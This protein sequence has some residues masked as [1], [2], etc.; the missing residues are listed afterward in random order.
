MQGRECLFQTPMSQLRDIRS[1][2]LQASVTNDWRK[3]EGDCSNL[4]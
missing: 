4:A 2:G 1:P 3:V